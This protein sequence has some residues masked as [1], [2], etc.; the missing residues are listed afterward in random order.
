MRVPAAE[1]DVSRPSRRWNALARATATVRGA[2]R[3]ALA[4]VD[5]A[6][7]P[8]SLAVALADDRR[9]RDLNA[10]WRGKDR[11]TN[12]LSFPA[13][14]GPAGAGRF[15]GDVILAFETVAREA[16]EQGK[17]LADHTAHL[18]VHGTLHLAGLDHRDEREAEAMEAAERAILAGLGIADPYADSE[19]LAM[20]DA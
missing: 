7:T 5:P 10:R 1:I 11:A 16:E 8:V 19:P 15:L 12:V 13:P 2:A 6:G 20:E 3:A 17:T 4:H 18:V 9:V 14:A